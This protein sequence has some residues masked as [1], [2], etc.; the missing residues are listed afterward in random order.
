MKQALIESIEKRKTNFDQMRAIAQAYGSNRECSVQEAVYNCLPEL[1]LRKVFPG[2]PN[3]RKYVPPRE[4]FQ[5]A[6]IKGR[7]QLPS[8]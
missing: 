3:L 8:R 1:W 5:N 7:N 2:V 6:L 4:K